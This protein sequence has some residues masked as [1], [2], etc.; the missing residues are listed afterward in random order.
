M[1]SPSNSQ[2]RTAG[3]LAAV[4]APC[5]G[6]FTTRLAAQVEWQHFSARAAYAM[7]AEP[8]TG[9]IAAFGGL[10]S[11]GAMGELGYYANSAWSTAGAGSMPPPTVGGAMVSTGPIGVLLLFGG[12]VGGVRTN[13]T[14]IFIGNNASQQGHAVAPS[15]RAYHAMAYM[16]N[17]SRVVL[18]G[19]EGNSG[20]LDD[21]WEW[22]GVQWLLRSPTHRPPPVS[23]HA[24]A[25]DSASQRV[26]M[27]D[28]P[29]APTAEYDGFDWAFVNAA[30]PPYSMSGC[31]TS[32]QGGGVWYFG[33]LSYI[34]L[35]PVADL[36]RYGNGNWTTVRSG[37]Y[38][39]GPIPR[40]DAQISQDP[41]S[42][43]VVLHGGIYRESS[44]TDTIL[45]D[46][47]EWTG[48]QW[49]ASAGT[50]SPI[51]TCAGAIAFDST[52]QRLLMHGGLIGNSITGSFA[53]WRTWAWSGGRWSEVATGPSV[54]RHAM[55]YDSHRDRLVLFGGLSGDLQWA[56]TYEFDGTAW[57]QR[58]P[59]HRP[60][61]RLSA[62]MAYDVVRHRVVLF[63]GGY[64]Q[65]WPDNNETWEYDG[66][67]WVQ[68]FPANS[69]P[70]AG[71]AVMCYDDRAGRL[72]LVDAGVWTWNGNNW[73]LLD[74]AA[75]PGDGP[76]V[77]DS[78]R[79]RLVRASGHEWSDLGW[80]TRQLGD[81]PPPFDVWGGFGFDPFQ[82]ECVLFGGQTTTNLIIGDTWRY[83]VTHPATTTP[84]GTGCPSSAAVT[85]SLRPN[86]LPPWLGT[87]F[88]VGTVP[89]TAP[90]FCYGVLGVDATVWGNAPLPMSLT[91]YGLT[92]CS[93]F[94]APLVGTLT[95]STDWHVMIPNQPGLMGMPVYLQAFP[96]ASYSNPAGVIA[97]DALRLQLGSR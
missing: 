18:F 46:T 11:R 13:A 63:G 33:G 92:A 7:A 38:L 80:Q 30:V 84:F 69:P 40:T 39:N 44:L 22:D 51:A 16:A 1:K 55:A 78:S 56:A 15:P 25:Y 66:V 8:G 12:Q 72:L 62:A 36:W 93:L 82:G 34:N 87:D 89:V 26:V 50:T 71:G 14:W 68:R 27:H 32:A 67:D 86:S 73:I 20:L 9:R 24:M 74:A 2:A 59:I 88:V 76:C 91:P 41:I 31:M 77:F 75:P 70:I 49:Q 4:C 94:V 47:W 52:R 37:S 95:T 97:T 96:L 6:M 85:Y 81:V 54:E 53:S 10:G 42:G 23:H 19:G 57:I 5:L 65:N 35:A 61:A 43:N 83:G 90:V 21:T 28:S 60:S 3:F 45:A 58:N 29:W 79:N 48:S 64:Q 17:R